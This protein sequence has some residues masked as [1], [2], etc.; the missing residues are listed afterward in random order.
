MPL[1][2]FIEHAHGVFRRWKAEDRRGALLPD[3]HETHFFHLGDDVEFHKSVI[4]I[5]EDL[6]EEVR[7]GLPLPFQDTTFLSIVTNER[8][9]FDP[10]NPERGDPCWTLD[11]VIEDP[12][13]WSDLFPTD[14]PRCRG[15]IYDIETGKRIDIRPEDYPVRSRFIV[16]RYQITDS[17]KLPDPVMWGCY[18]RGVVGKGLFLDVAGEEKFNPVPVGSSFQKSKLTA[19]EWLTYESTMILEQ[20]A[21]V[22][23][24]MNYIV[25]ESPFLTPREQRKLEK[26]GERPDRKRDRYIVVDHEVL[27]RMSNA[28]YGTHASPVPHERRGHWMRLSERCRFALRAGKSRVWV[29]PAYVGDRMFQNDKARYEVLMDSKKREAGCTA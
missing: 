9:S 24:P 28:K 10:R 11:R 3:L 16:V 8:P 15:E 5:V 7:H 12:P 1:D 6:L 27:V 17:I 19:Q 21:A 23:H 13:Y 25:R 18:Y 14:D 22:S 20:A 2:D 29:R 26:T 4:A